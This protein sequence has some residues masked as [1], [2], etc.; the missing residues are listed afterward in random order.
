MAGAQACDAAGVDD[1]AGSLAD[2]DRRH[3]LHAE[4]DTAQVGGDDSVEVLHVDLGDA[5]N[6]AGVA[7]VVEEAVDAAEFPQRL[8]DQRRDVGLVGDVGALEDGGRTELVRQA[9]LSPSACLRPAMTTWAPSSTNSSAVRAPMPLVLP[10]I[11]AILPS[12]APMA[13]PSPFSANSPAT[14]PEQGPLSQ[15]AGWAIDPPGSS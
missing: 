6:A 9:R 7:G 1:A 12:S 5:G 13:W 3:E 14:M 2:H 4:H 8:L 11:T 10:V 15:Q